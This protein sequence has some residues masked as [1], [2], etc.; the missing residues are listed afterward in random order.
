MKL[1]LIMLLLLAASI[2]A[3][4]SSCASAGGSSADGQAAV[5]EIRLSRP[6]LDKPVRR[7]LG[8]VQISWD[9]VENAASYKVEKSSTRRFETVDHTWTVS[10][11][12][13]EMELNPG[14]SFW[15]RVQAVNRDAASRWS[16][17]IEV[18]EARL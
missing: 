17:E 3:F 16:P 10:G 11:T 12:S 14:D 4:F 6:I 18:R 8:L 2:S 5:E 13:L 15:I 7:P 9:R 1:R